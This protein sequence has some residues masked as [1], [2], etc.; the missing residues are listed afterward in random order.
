MPLD[1]H[2]ARVLRMLAAGGEPAQT[3]VERRAGLEKLAEIATGEPLS[4]AS[5]KD[6]A[7]SLDRSCPG[8]RRYDAEGAAS[9]PPGIVY[10]HGGGWVAGSLDTHD[11][12]CRALAASTGF[13]V[14]SVDYRLA[15]EH[16]FPTG[17]QD[18][19]A[20]VRWL[21]RHGTGLD[22]D[23]ARL[24]LA[25][26]SAGGGLAA[27]AAAALRDDEGPPLK[28][29][30]L[31]CP[32]LD[33]AQ[34]RPSRIEFGEGHFI[35][36]AAFAAD[37]A[38]YANP[39]ADLSDPDISPLQASDFTGLPPALIH[40]AE[41]DP[42]RD[43][44]AAYADRLKEA[45]VPVTRTLHS[46]MIHYFYALPRLIPHASAALAQIGAELRQAVG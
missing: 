14:F 3:V 24:V 38:G 13:T 28:A 37:V 44:G 1:P 6:I 35:S 36:R 40:L 29:L 46:G 15:P 39:D 27:A 20:A 21:R 34:L 8:M 23:P 30:L 19:L 17:L 11:S 2:C 9:L 33:L 31:V 41:F 4:L 43:E 42:F 32:I 45:G 5:I 16:P 18:A 12:V 25:G 10:L 22:V 26:D 7:P